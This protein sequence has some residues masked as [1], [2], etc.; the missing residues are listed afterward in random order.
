VPVQGGEDDYKPLPPAQQR[1]PP[2]AGANGQASGSEPRCRLLGQGGCSAR[3]AAQ[4]GHPA[5]AMG[6]EP[7][8]R[9]CQLLPTVTPLARTVRL[10]DTLRSSEWRLL[11]P[12]AQITLTMTPAGPRFSYQ[13][14]SGRK[15]LSSWRDF[16]RAIR[17]GCS[18]DRSIRFF[19]FYRCRTQQQKRRLAPLLGHPAHKALLSQGFA[20]HQILQKSSKIIFSLRNYL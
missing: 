3:G 13:T 4:L 9:L 5:P 10:T 14:Y 7:W 12:K 19:Y 18:E 16:V 8:S 11:T 15:G 1:A 6:H 17:R 20:E 2:G